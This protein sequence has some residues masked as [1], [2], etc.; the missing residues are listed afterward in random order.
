MAMM[1]GLTGFGDVG[2]CCISSTEASNAMDECDVAFC[3]LCSGMS[4]VLFLR[5]LNCEYA[6]SPSVVGL[7][8]AEV[9]TTSPVF[10]RAPYVVEM[11]R[12]SGLMPLAPKN[13]GLHHQ[14]C[15][16]CA[17]MHKIGLQLSNKTNG[18]LHTAY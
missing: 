18:E 11:G 9:R 17:T 8:C 10:E 2:Q 16:V 3:I 4:L 1:V 7:S 13:K 5:D 14:M 6:M 12:S 15:R